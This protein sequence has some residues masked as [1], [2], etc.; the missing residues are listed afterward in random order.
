MEATAAR[1]RTKLLVWVLFVIFSGVF[2]N[3]FLSWGMKHAPALTASPLSYLRV[4]MNPAVILGILL[5]ISWML[6]RMALMSW[7]DLSFVQPVTAIG[8]VLSAIMGQL[9]LG[10]HVSLQRWSGTLLIMAGTALVS[11]TTPKTTK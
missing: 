8:Y 4:M 6:S 11:V 10:E 1:P 9:F 5:L 2:G 3:F 7:A